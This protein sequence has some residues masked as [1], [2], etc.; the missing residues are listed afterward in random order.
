GGPGGGG[1]RGGFGG[2]GGRGGGGGGGGG[3]P[4]AGGRGGRP[5]RGMGDRRRGA[6]RGVGDSLG[7]RS[8]Q[9]LIIAQTDSSLT[10]EAAGRPPVVLMFDGRPVAVR[11]GPGIVPIQVA[12]HWHEGRFQV[13]RRVGSTTITETYERSKDRT[14]LTVRTRVSD[15]F[16]E[17]SEV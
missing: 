2:R 13:E 14:R 1:G 8:P 6:G 4:A 5:G 16:G 12:G 9:Q 17:G 10:L 3:F 11:N 15:N 7:G